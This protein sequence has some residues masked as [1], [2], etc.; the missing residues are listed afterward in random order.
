MRY[1]CL[2]NSFYIFQS[3]HGGPVFIERKRRKFELVGITSKPSKKRPALH[4]KIYTFLPFII[5]QLKTDRCTE[6]SPPYKPRR[7]INDLLR[8]EAI[9]SSPFSDRF[10]RIYTH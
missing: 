10:A 4:T 2:P 7:W 6:N 9:I 8:Y 1:L 3:D 5:Q